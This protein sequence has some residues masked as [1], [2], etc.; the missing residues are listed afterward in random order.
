MTILAQAFLQQAEEY[1]KNA[2]FSPNIIGFNNVYNLYKKFTSVKRDIFLIEKMLMGADMMS[3]FEN[4]L[5]DKITENHCILAFE[6]LDAEFAIKYLQ[7][8]TSEDEIKE[9]NRFGLTQWNRETHCD[10]IHRTFAEYFCSQLLVLWLRQENFIAENPI[11]ADSKLL[12]NY[13]SNRWFENEEAFRDKTALHV[14]VKENNP[15]IIDFFLGGMDTE[16]NRTAFVSFLLARDCEG[17]TA[18]KR[19]LIILYPRNYNPESPVEHNEESSSKEYIVKRIMQN[20]SHLPYK[21]KF[22][23]LLYKGSAI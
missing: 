17:F 5:C 23:I 20:I 10:F 11:T 14:A 16:E 19:G 21:F 13:M 4:I 22:K 8:V 9:M 12:F 15:N 1:S 2:E 3:G 7:V 18:L 6:I